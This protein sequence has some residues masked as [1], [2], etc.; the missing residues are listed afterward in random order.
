MAIAVGVNER[1]DPTVLS[2]SN[3]SGTGNNAQDLQNQFLTMLVTQLKN[4]D[5]T[6][7]MD[8]SQ[9]TTQLAQINTL[10]GIEKLNTT[11]GS[12]SGQISTSQSLQSSTLI[13]HGVMVNG[14]QILVGNGTTTPFGVELASAST[15]TS[16]TIKDASGTV[17]DTVDLGALSAGVHTFSWDGKLTDG[18]VAPDGKYS[19]AIAASNGNTQLVAQPLNYA[20]V[21]GVSTAN[22][23]TKLDLGTMGSAT[24]DDVRQIL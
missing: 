13:G 6:N 16:A 7:P 3:T 10:S 17:I 19:V 18:S 8:N 1:L 23:T 4:Q 14:G 22:N 5:P 24:L 2:S 15:G 20:Y 11:L 9:L 21:N 12:I